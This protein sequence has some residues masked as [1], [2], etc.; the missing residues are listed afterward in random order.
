MSNETIEKK[1]KPKH[2]VLK[3]F[4]LVISMGIMVYCILLLLPYI[5]PMGG[6]F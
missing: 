6:A 2:R 4:G 5:F 1:K 3:F